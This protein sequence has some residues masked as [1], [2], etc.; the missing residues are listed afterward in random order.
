MPI[1]EVPFFIKT[2]IGPFRSKQVHLKPPSSPHVLHNCGII[3]GALLQPTSEHRICQIARIYCQSISQSRYASGQ[4]Y[5]RVFGIAGGRKL[6]GAADVRIA[7]F[8]C[9][10]LAIRPPRYASSLQTTRP[11]PEETI[12]GM[13][14]Y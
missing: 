12:I 6:V 1:P 14:V 11:A 7:D 9:T 8:I 5:K 10:D 3:L 4:K 13:L 2:F